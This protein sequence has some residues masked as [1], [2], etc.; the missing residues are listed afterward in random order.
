MDRFGRL[1]SNLGFYQPDF[2]VRHW[3]CLG[4]VKANER[5]HKLFNQKCIKLWYLIVFSSLFLYANVYTL[6]H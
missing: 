5:V 4:G 6:W 2:G 1:I 3:P